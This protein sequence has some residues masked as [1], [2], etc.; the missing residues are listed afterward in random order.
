MSSTPR[1]GVA[2][3]TPARTTVSH[4]I[5]GLPLT[6][7]HFVILVIAALG[8]AFDSFDTYIVS[9]AM[10]SITNEWKLDAVTTGALASTGIW[11][12]FFGAIIWGPVAD[13]FGRRA[14]FSGTIL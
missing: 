4:V 8:V 5:E 1:A 7:A 11:G 6:R 10:P 14:A 12:M 3:A 9:Y 13:R 2:A